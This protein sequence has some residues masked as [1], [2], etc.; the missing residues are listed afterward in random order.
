[1]GL[2]ETRT[3]FVNLL[4]E[5][6]GRIEIERQKEI[7]GEA[8]GDMVVSSSE[9][10]NIEIP[11]NKV[12]NIIDEIPILSV[13]GLFAEGDFSIHNAGELRK[14]ESDRINSLC[15][16]FRKLGIPIEEYEDGFKLSGKI[17]D[18]YNVFDSF[19]DHRIAMAF[20]ILSLLLKDGGKIGNFE[21]VNISNPNF[22]RQINEIIV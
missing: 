7:S 8:F 1:V 19:N 2:N 6:G 17:N 16:N 18:N 4:K 5:M 15:V 20:G 22:L 9:L 21:C 10:K 11:Q 13:A 14:K 12:P 3:G